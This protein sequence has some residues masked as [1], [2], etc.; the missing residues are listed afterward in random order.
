MIIEIHY[1]HT[2]LPTMSLY[3]YQIKQKTSGKNSRRKIIVTHTRLRSSFTYTRDTHTAARHISQTENFEKRTHAHMFTVFRVQI[4]PR[5]RVRV[6]AR[7][8]PSDTQDSRCRRRR[9]QRC[10]WM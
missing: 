2:E 4:G 8:A 3:S 1:I 6:C 7:P 5:V 9:R 10:T